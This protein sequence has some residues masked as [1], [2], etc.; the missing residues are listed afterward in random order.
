M[1][2]YDLEEQEQLD[3]L[4]AWWN[5]YGRLVIVAVCAF[6]ITIVLFLGWRSYR[7]QQSAGAAQLYTTLKTAVEEKDAKKIRDA[8]GAIVEKFP[9][10]GYAALA[11]L[12]LAKAN[13]ESGDKAGAKVQLQWVIEHAREEEM[14]DVARLRLAAVL[15]D[16]KDHA[17]A[18]KLAE[19]KH[20]EAFD[21]LY[22]DLKGDILV[23]QGNRAEA[24]AAYQAALD[25]SDARSAFRNLVQ[26]KLDAL[27][28]AK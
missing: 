18:L 8:G 24:R 16:E 7:Q 28:D 13:F 19:T 9:S 4:K 21:A 3:A 5:Q 26:L 14:R 11:A 22:A 6:L 20:A 10:T 23:A 1:A 27:G 25:K 2:V 17:Q 15:L 12:A